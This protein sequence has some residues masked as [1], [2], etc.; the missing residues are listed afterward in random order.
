MPLTTER[1]VQNRV[2]IHRDIATGNNYNHN[3]HHHHDDDHHHHNDNHPNGHYNLALCTKWL[4]WTLYTFYQSH[5]EISVNWCVG[6]E[7]A[8][9][10]KMTWR[11]QDP[12]RTVCAGQEPEEGD[13]GDGSSIKYESDSHV[14]SD[15]IIILTIFIY[16]QKLSH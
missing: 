12:G 7:I 9:D 2:K 4:N 15:C 10:L 13:A 3:H 8:W 6:C 5:I 14:E 1:Q 11:W 16:L